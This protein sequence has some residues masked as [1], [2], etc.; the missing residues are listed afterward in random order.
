MPVHLFTGGGGGQVQGYSVRGDW[1]KNVPVPLEVVGTTAVRG[2]QS[3]FELTPYLTL[4]MGPVASLI[5][6][7]FSYLNCTV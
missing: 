3:V 4:Q 1:L 5:Q 2:T 7:E 6:V